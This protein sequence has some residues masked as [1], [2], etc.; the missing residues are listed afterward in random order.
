MGA[1][2]TAYSRGRFPNSV[3]VGGRFREPGVRTTIP[4]GRYREPDKRQ[5]PPFKSE[6][7]RGA[8]GIAVETRDSSGT[9]VGDCEVDLFHSASDALVARAV[10]DGGG[11]VT[12]IIGNNSDYYYVRAY[13]A[14]APDLAGTTVN[15]LQAS[16]LGG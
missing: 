13:K 6:R 2:G 15:T 5:H 11:L 8:F 12:I 10:S 1:S 3:G 16:Y 7:F 9:L 14:G 4:G